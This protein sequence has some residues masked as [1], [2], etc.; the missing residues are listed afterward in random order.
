MFSHRLVEELLELDD[1]GWAIAIALPHTRG[2]RARSTYHNGCGHRRRH[3]DWRATT[4]EGVDL[5][6]CRS[7]DETGRLREAEG[8]K[9]FGSIFGLEALDRC[10]RQGTEAVRFL[11]R[12]A[13]AAYRH[14]RISICVQKL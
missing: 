6:Q 2:D 4:L 11:P 1:I 13:H 7:I 9:N 8:R 3:R 10:S 12:S 14:A 5:A